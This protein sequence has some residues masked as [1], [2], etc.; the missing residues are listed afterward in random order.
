MNKFVKKSHKGFT[1]IQLVIGMLIF[2]ILTGIAFYGVSVYTKQA[3]ETRVDSDLGTFE[4]ALKDYMLNNQNACSDGT[5]NLVSLNNYLT[6]ENKVMKQ[7]GTEAAPAAT[8]PDEKSEVGRSVLKDP[9]GHEYYIVIDNNEDEPAT[10]TPGINSR[11]NAYIYVYTAGKDGRA[12]DNADQK[13]GKT[14]T[15]KGAT[16]LVGDVKSPSFATDAIEADQKKDDSVLVVS[17]HD[18]EVYS[19]VYQP[20]DLHDDKATCTAGNY[21][22]KF[23]AQIIPFIVK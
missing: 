1:I 8:A 14:F 17:Y 23:N 16:A 21:D 4:V 2:A 7:G 15:Y 13:A 3:N 10:A 11:D 12:S 20:S 6:D 18:G 9:W 19:H 22:G 5:L